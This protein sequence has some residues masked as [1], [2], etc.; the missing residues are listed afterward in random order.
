MPGKTTISFVFTVGF[1]SF[2]YFSEVSTEFE[3]CPETKG[4]G[5]NTM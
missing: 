4:G 1:S 2:L 5:K 3:I